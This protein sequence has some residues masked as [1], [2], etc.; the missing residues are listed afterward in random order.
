MMR[1]NLA[2]V[3]S[4]STAVSNAAVWL[5]V[6]AAVVAVAVPWLP[7]F[8]SPAFMRWA[9]EVMCYLILAQ[10]W[11]LMAGYAGLMS[12]GMQ[13]FVGVGG[14]SVFIFAQHL[15]V[16]PF[17]S[18]PIAG[19]M[20]AVAAALTSP[21]VFR[22][23]G[24]YF[25][26]GTW[27]LSEVFRIG[28]SNVSALGGGSGQSLTVMTR[29]DRSTREIAIY[30][31]AATTLILASVGINLLLRSRFGLGLTALRDS[32]AA[33]ESQGVDVR[34]LKLQ[35]YTLSS[36]GAGLVGAIYYTSVLRISPFAAF[37]LN[38]VVAATFIVVIGGIGAVEGPIVGAAIFFALRWL[39]ADY[40]TWYWLV[41][42]SVAVIV[43]MFAP[44]GVWGYIRG[45]WDI[46]LLPLQ[47]RLVLLGPSK[48]GGASAAP[49]PHRRTG[50]WQG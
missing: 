24:G 33:A 4:R 45:R 13:A 47:R 12:V 34:L 23:R 42:G 5:G 38:W 11:N 16:N 44:A 41:M 2:Y 35:V 22:M 37:D 49:S 17:L 39:L 3:V 30:L 9:T 15:G 27:V 21:L 29:I 7:Y 26:I 6:A 43:I 31:I 50:A 18:I 1:E 25:A 48:P 36:L 46:Q 40:G 32:E 28:F 10:M 8:G 20:A 14:Y 19:V